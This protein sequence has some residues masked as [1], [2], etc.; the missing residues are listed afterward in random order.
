MNN[1]F[2]LVYDLQARLGESPFWDEVSQ[3][4]WLTDING[5]RLHRFDPQRG[6]YSTR[7]LPEELGCFAPST[8]TGFIAAMRSG[9]W[10]L[11]DTESETAG[12]QRKCLVKNPEGYAGSRFNDGIIDARGR[13]LSGTLDPD[14]HSRAGLYRYDNRG[15]VRLVDGL[16][17]SNGLAFSPD[18]RTLYHADTP[19]FTVYAYDY[20]IDKGDISNKRMFIQIQ[21]TET[22][23]GRPDG[24]A[25]DVDGCYWTA[26]YQGARVHRYSPQGEL[27]ESYAVAA[28]SPTMP[29]FGGKDMRTL[30]VT[31]ARDGCSAEQ[32][33]AFPQSGG[34][35]AMRVE[36]PG[37]AKH[38][39]NPA[40]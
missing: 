30:Y 5:K 36:T 34:I 24:A 7:N 12:K 29:C 2:E 27:I 4:L 6:Q 31:S 33:A 16:I 13:L 37:L 11:P 17:T 38:R 10:H 3:T 1:R 8:T 32:L 28:Q 40:A 35:F 25:V 39:F 22:D 15:L 14:K 18:G 20:D 23:R 21:P 9:I 26:L 19:R